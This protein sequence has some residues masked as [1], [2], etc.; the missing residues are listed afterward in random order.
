M[1]SNRRDLRIKAMQILYAWEISREPIEEIVRTVG[2]EIAEEKE[3]FALLERIVYTVMDHREECDAQIAALAANWEFDRI[4]IIDRILLR[5][6]ICE[7]LYFPEIPPKATIN[8]AIE[9]AKR[10]STE[11]SGKFVNG[12]LDAI[13]AD[14][15][16][17]G[18]LNKS[19]RGLV[20]LN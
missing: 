18:T 15:K 9:I 4:A 2:E 8:E 5:I 14:L 6:G 12:I 16:Q 13:L 7:L 1:S 3:H 20:G 10:Y 19:G 17:K 11:K